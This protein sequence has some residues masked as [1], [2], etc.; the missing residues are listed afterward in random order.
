ME[1]RLQGIRGE[2]YENDNARQ[3]MEEHLTKAYIHS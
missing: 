3:R 1:K 2:E